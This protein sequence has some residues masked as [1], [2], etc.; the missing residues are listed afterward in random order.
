[1]V[2]FPDVVGNPEH[3]LFFDEAAEIRYDYNS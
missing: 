2:N 3:S 1:M